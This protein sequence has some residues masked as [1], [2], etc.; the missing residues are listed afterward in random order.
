MTASLQQ[1]LVLGSGGLLDDWMEQNRSRPYY[2]EIKLCIAL[3]QSA[4][5]ELPDKKY[6]ADTLEW[7]LDD[8]MDFVEAGVIP[9]NVA[10][11]VVGLDPSALRS[12]ILKSVTNRV[13]SLRG[14]KR[15]HINN[16]R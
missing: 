15:G 12:R 10:C 8:S 16:Y 1:A 4:L 11:Y 6:F 7:I 9:F 2:A 13:V 3:L 5:V 14:R